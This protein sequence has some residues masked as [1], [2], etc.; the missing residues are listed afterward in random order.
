M[1]ELQETQLGQDVRGD[2]LKPACKEGD[3]LTPGC[4]ERHSLQDQDVRGDIFTPRCK[5]R[6]TPEYEG[7]HVHTRM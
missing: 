2:T 4:G 6:N 1:R 7:K 5:G 3:R